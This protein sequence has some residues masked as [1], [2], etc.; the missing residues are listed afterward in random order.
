[1]SNVRIHK[2][3]S[4]L[5]ESARDEKPAVA[6][7]PGPTRL[8]VITG[9]TDS[10][11]NRKWDLFL[12]DGPY[13]NYLVSFV[14]R[15]NIFPDRRDR[16]EEAVMNACEKI[17]KFMI[18]KRFDYPEEG[19]GRFRGFLK[20]VAIREALKLR[21]QISRQEQIRDTES[22][23]EKKLELDEMLE[24]MERVNARGRKKTGIASLDDNPFSEDEMPVNYNPADMFDFKANVSKEDLKWV[25][26]LQIHVLYIALG[27][28]LSNKKVSAERRELLRLRY[29]QD[30]K[31]ED[32][33]KM[34]RFA[35]MSRG[36]IDTKMCYARDDL[37]E[38]VKSW[39]ELVKPE[40]NVF[41][42][43]TVL[44]FWRELARPAENADLVRE[45]QGKAN[46]VAGRI[47]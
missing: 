46:S 32:V 38:E 4:P 14:Q 44:K 34:P 11:T 28:V 26:K 17:G 16:V 10:P 12:R 13:W 27:Y 41:A 37:R 3:P 33:Y 40:K 39:W 42:D 23:E 47:R 8:S 7:Y 1:M 2:A 21:E 19:K 36:A 20:V 24:H 43:E 25:Q 35:S 30:M 6:R 45:L 18:A 9:L 22:K 31:M 5:E 15:R 29:G